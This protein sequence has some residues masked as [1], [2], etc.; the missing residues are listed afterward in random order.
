MLIQPAAGFAGRELPLR[1]LHRQPEPKKEDPARGDERGL[2][3]TAEAMT[4]ESAAREEERPQ[5]L[6]KDYLPTRCAAQTLAR[7]GCHAFSANW[8]TTRMARKKG[9]IRRWGL[10]DRAKPKSKVWQ[11]DEGGGY[12]I[13]RWT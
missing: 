6:H 4:V 7:N 2:R 10:N 12:A 5:T 9:P 8:R 13:C 3:V 11:M 1:R